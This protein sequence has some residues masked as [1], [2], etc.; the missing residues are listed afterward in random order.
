[1]KRFRRV[2]ALIL[3]AVLCTAHMAMP[4]LSE[5]TDAEAVYAAEAMAGT[6]DV[7]EVQ[8]EVGV[9]EDLV[10]A[11][12]E[13]EVVEAQDVDAAVGEV[14]VLL[15]DTGDAVLSFD[16]AQD[17]EL[18]DPA[19][20]PETLLPLC[21]EADLDADAFDREPEALRQEQPNGRTAPL[22]TPA[23]LQSAFS[24]G[25]RSPSRSEAADTFLPMSPKSCHL[26]KCGIITAAPSG[27]CRLPPK[28][29]PNHSESVPRREADPRI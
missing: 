19:E 3:I 11:L 6:G 18:P 14:V 22:Q 21:E 26:T 24:P 27:G 10:A 13:D 29:A 5:T 7:A 4:A 15:S 20:A 9:T 16:G 1:M 8:G 2:L 23:A 25:R 12:P 28:T 17:P